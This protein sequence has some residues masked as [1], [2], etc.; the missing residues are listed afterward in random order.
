MKKVISFSLWGN[1][2]LY[3]RGAIKNAILAKTVYPGWICR[4]YIPKE[5]SRYTKNMRP[6]KHNDK[7]KSYTI[8]KVPKQVIAELEKHGA[9]IV[10]IDSDGCWY[11]MFW[12]FYAIG[13]ADVAIFRDCD[14]RLSFREKYAVEQWLISDKKV[15]IMRDHPWHDVA[16]L[17]G[18]W[19]LKKGILDDIKTKIEKISKDKVGYWQCD[20]EFLKSEYRRLLPHAMVHNEFIKAQCDRGAEFIKAESFA[21]PFPKKRYKNQFIGQPYDEN[22]KTLITLHGNMNKDTITEYFELDS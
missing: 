18:M 12:R 17:G 6:D 9:E 13:D 14:S 1:I 5:N 7:D 21:I 20:Q 8:T 3:T 15:H 4:F 19:G 16:I 22:N 2:E 10:K 11:S